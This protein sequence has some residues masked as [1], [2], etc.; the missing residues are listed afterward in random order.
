MASKE[1]E[2]IIFSGWQC[3]LLALSQSTEKVTKYADESVR[4]NREHFRD[5]KH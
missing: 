5:P 3:L 4:I 1:E 2:A